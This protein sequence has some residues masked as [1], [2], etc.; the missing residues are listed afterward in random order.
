MPHIA[1]QMYPGRDQKTKG[2]IAK[3]MQTALAE[4]MQADRNYFSV[5]IEDVAPEDWKVMVEEKIK[6]NNWFI[7]DKY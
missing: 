1:I 7:P 4:E 3:R 6:P 5:S 2:R